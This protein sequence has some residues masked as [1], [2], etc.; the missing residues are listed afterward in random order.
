MLTCS[1]TWAEN[2]GGR[3]CSHSFDSVSFV[4]GVQCLNLFVVHKC[5][6]PH[7]PALSY[8]GTVP[9]TNQILIIVFNT[10]N[11]ELNPICHLLALLG[12]HHIFHISGLRVKLLYSCSHNNYLI[13]FC[14]FVIKMFY[15]YKLL[16]RRLQTADQRLAFPVYFKTLS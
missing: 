3:G 11:T 1:I 14:H 2:C 9:S 8:W 7:V 15:M 13:F 4:L 5:M 6:H 10:L 16:C 12:A